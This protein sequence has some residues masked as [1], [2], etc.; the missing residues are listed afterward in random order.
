MFSAHVDSIKD[1]G[2]KAI[3]LSEAVSFR[4]KNNEWP[5]NT[6]VITFDDGFANFYESAWPVL[7]QHRFSATVFVISGYMGCKNDWDQPPFS[8]GTQP[9]LSWTQAAEL[10]QAGIEIGSHTKTHPDLRRCSF[11][12]VEEQLSAS[13]YEIE[14]RLG[15]AVKSFAYPYGAT[16]EVIQRQASA[17]FSCACTTVLKR[18]NGESLHSLP[19]V[20]AYYMKSAARLQLLLQGE[21]DTYLTFRRFGRLARK[22]LKLGSR[23]KY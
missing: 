14:D 20:D 10:A 2:Y 3:S 12:E 17:V 9:L 15:F 22:T 23:A 4:E 21:L 13:R 6:V 5:T 8:L 16:N 19:R 11:K 1:S 18:A 7:A